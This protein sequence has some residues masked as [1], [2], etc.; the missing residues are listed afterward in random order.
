[1]GPFR[2]KKAHMARRILAPTA[3]RPARGS[4][5]LPTAAAGLNAAVNQLA[6]PIILENLFQTALGT[7]SMLMVSQ[8]GAAAIAGIG[9]ATQL[10]FVVQAAFGAVTTGTT[11]LVARFTGA[12]E[13][14]NANDVVRQS[15]LVGTLLSILF[16]FLGV[17]LSEW[18]IQLMGAEPEVVAAG[19]VYLRITMAA[20]FFLITMFTISGALRGAGDSRT[21]MVVSG[22]INVINVGLSYVLIFGKLGLPAM[23]IAGAGW[24]VTISRA[25]GTLLL[26]RFLVKGDSVVSIRGRRGWAPD[27]TL[28]WRMMRLG[29]PSMGEQ[30]LMSGGMLIYGIISISLG[31]TI[32][33]AQRITF[34]AM[35]LAFQPGMG[36]ALA[37]TAIVGQYL[38]AKR[39]E[40]AERATTHCLRMAA[41]L[42]TTVGVI[43]AI[44]GGPIMRLFTDDAQM[45]AIG[46]QA[47]WVIAAAWPTMAVAQVMAGSLRGAGDTRFPMYTTFLGIWLM[48]VP[49][50]YLFGPVLGWGLSGIYIANVL[51]SAARGLAGWLRYR[52]GGWRDIEV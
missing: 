52:T 15:L 3:G 43:M 38:G 10:L 5:V 6:W 1:M 47:L 19:G 37:A 28:M 7:V 36:Y 17:T 32:Y 8:L 51:D 16:G 49:L 25:I 23:G 34:Q 13:P 12:R 30:L 14:H 40:L 9:T 20:S 27:L 31:T 4:V 39:P 29:L 35:S 24:A 45:I 46:A 11:V 33:A 2:N 42:M 21:P 50:G 48:R 44:L 22:A 41:V 18:F 26:L